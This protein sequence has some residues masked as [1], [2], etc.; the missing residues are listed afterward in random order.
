MKAAIEKE[1]GA[2]STSRKNGT[3]TAKATTNGTPKS[4]GRKRA[5]SEDEE[6]YDEEDYEMETPAKRVKKEDS[7][8]NGI[9]TKDEAEA[10]DLER[11]EYG[12]ERLNETLC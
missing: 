7:V 12:N 11:D 5:M 1:C 4:N 6:V 10:Y 3:A 9:I 2:G 8:V